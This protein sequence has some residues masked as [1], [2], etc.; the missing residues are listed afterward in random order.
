MAHKKGQG[1][2]RNGRDSQA[3]Y[4]GIKRHDGQIVLAGSII[5]RQVGTRF[6]PGEGAGEGRDHT[7]FARRDGVVKFHRRNDRRY[8]SIMPLEMA[9]D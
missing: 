1:S 6:H 8:I 7:V 5:V 2:T 9:A 3:Q 4:R